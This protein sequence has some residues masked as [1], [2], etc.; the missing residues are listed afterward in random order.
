MLEK[1]LRD[2]RRRAK[3]R[4]LEAAE[5]PDRVPLYLSRILQGVLRDFREE[6]RSRQAHRLVARVLEALAQETQ[7]P[8]LLQARL[9]ESQE[10]LLAILETLPDGSLGEI[11]LPE[12]PLL[13]TTLLTNARGEPRLLR[14]LASEIASADSIDLLMAF[15]RRSGIR[16]LRSLLEGH[17]KGGRPLRILTTTYTRSTEAEAL[18]ILKDLGAEVRVSYDTT[19]TRLHAKSWIFHRASGASTL[20]LGSSNLTHSAQVTGLEWNLR[21]SGLRNPEVLDKVQATFDSYWESG[22][23]EPFDALTFRARTRAAPEASE[24]FAY[25]EVRPEP[26][27]ERILE[28][29]EIER[30][31]GF[32]RNL[33]VAATGTGKTVISALDFRRL[34]RNLPRDR[35]LFL[36]HRKEILH[37]AQ[38]TFR[39]VLRQ[40]DFGEL[41]VDGAR[42]QDYHAVFASIQAWNEAALLGTDPSH[43]D[44]LILDEFHHARAPSYRRILEHFQP[45]ELLGLTATP[46]RGD[47]FDVSEL[48]GG[49]IAAELRLWD[50]IDRGR[51]T[52]FVYYGVAA[53]ADFRELS[54]KRGRG[55][56]P[57]EL[58]GV[59]TADH[60]Q[61]RRMLREVES[62]VDDLGSIRGLGFCVSVG[63]AEFLAQE[64]SKL[65]IASQ[66]ITGETDS[67]TRARALR[68]LEA[69][70]LRF[71]FC[72]DL[73]NEGVDLPRVDT[74]L[75]LRPTQS[76]TLFLQQLGR[77]LRRA[78]GKTVCTVF[79]FIGQHRRE[80]RFDQR[81]RGLF[82]GSR[83][84]LLRSVE[85]GFPQLPAGCHFELDPVSQ[86]RVLHQVRNAIPRNWAGKVQELK[87]LRSEFPRIR[88]REFLEETGYELEDLYRGKRSWTDLLEAAG[89]PVLPQGPREKAV[90]RAIGRLTHVNDPLRIQ[91]WRAL[92]QEG[93]TEV[94]QGRDFRLAQM[95]TST[96]TRSSTRSK[97]PWIEGWKLLRRHPG[98]LKEVLE[99]LEVLE[100]GSLPVPN[101]APGLDPEIPLSVHARYSR[102]EILAAFAAGGR[103]SR[104]SS[105][106]TGVRYLAEVPADLL[107]F[108]LDKSSGGFSPTTM[109]R[110]Y[111]IS[112]SLIHWESQSVCRE[113]SETGTRYQEHA[114]RGSQ[115]LLFARENPDRQ[116]LF[117]G[118]ASYV[119]HQGERPMAIVWRL[120]IPLPA[121]VYSEFKAVVG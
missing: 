63:H 34:R 99:L 15:I 52:P 7:E 101:P 95:L 67:P 65:G 28:A 79:D 22:D 46:E 93:S 4:A 30:N 94:P 60:L 70:S 25:L 11:P 54:W 116:F 75:F 14:Q 78:E 86:E 61:V 73:F 9:V 74:L 40:P 44:V 55:Y 72:V 114:E 5:I 47:G 1:A 12:T 118:P 68:Q 71:L 2:T 6:E 110:D 56:D 45:R 84:D 66:A 121:E 77:G 85:Q 82:G 39:A 26:F 88:L 117:L 115:V 17:C 120:K 53:G 90:R 24:S 23:F 59:L 38:A 105:W 18:E 111:A 106:Q 80:F 37:Q 109:Y 102:D 113:D 119:R 48:F 31:R 16:P 96:L 42:P 35:L 19:G 21:V 97:T 91:A 49:R 76:S 13:D 100:T 50:A 20:Y 112:S 89:Y 69:G 108:T 27:Q 10:V 8:D 64:C 58:E 87:S 57:V 43:F 103:G 83:R 3:R 29:L 33:V 51:L 41:W 92:L 32:H 81:L 36:A 62:R 98:A 104:V 107:A